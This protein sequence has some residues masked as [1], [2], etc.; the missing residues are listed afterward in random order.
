MRL[1]TIDDPMDPRVADYRDIKDAELRRRAGLFVAESRAVVHRLLASARFRTRSVLLTQ[2]ALDGLRGALETCDAPVYLTTHE[3][4]RDVLGFDFHRG[5]IALGERGHEP[6]AA[7]L[8]DAEGPRLVVA[9]EGVS[10]PDNVGSVFRNA[11]ALGADAILLS[12]G[13]ADPLYRKTIRVSMGTALET[14][15][16]HVP[17]WPT[18]LTRLRQA[19]YTIVALTPDPCAHDIAQL[20][21][22]APGSR[23]ALLVGAEHH[24][25]GAGSRA[26]ADMTVRIAMS[27]GAD[28]LNVATATAIALHRLRPP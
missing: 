4:A 26:A 23:V 17:E 1:Q 14:P 2:P 8:I 10:N 22:M 20:D 9:M 16:A 3:V 5:C 28:S 25:L 19:R 18:G 15:F 27:P 12:S 13:C 24:G 6:S 7:A 11:S 21:P